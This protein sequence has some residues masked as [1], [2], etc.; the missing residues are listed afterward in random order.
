M[1][2]TPSSSSEVEVK[3]KELP[4]EKPPCDPYVVFPL[5]SLGMIPSLKT[6][7]D[8][9]HGLFTPEGTKCQ[10]VME[11]TLTLCKKLPRVRGPKERATEFP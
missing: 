4:D 8:S 7:H 9:L 3:E 2:P 6:H 11:P 5:Q 10:S 1:E